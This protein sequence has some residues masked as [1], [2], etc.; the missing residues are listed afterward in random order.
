MSELFGTK[1]FNFIASS[2]AITFIV[3]ILMV[4]AVLMT[5]SKR[6][7]EM[8]RLEKLGLKRASAKQ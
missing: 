4:V 6:K 1:Y 3:L 5:Y 2:Y 7:R 8:A